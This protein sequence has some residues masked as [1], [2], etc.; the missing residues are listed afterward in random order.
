MIKLHTFAQR[1]EYL[2]EKCNIDRPLN[3]GIIEELDGTISWSKLMKLE[4]A[5]EDEQ[6]AL[7]LTPNSKATQLRIQELKDAITEEL[8]EVDDVMKAIADRA[9]AD[10]IRKAKEDELMQSYK[11]DVKALCERINADSNKYRSRSL[12]E[13]SNAIRTGI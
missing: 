9:K 8:S 2:Q 6:E 13:L 10:V 1:R 7:N 12:A 11:A 4:S 5:I 3:V